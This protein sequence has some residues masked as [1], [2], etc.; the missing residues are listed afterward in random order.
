[1]TPAAAQ[2]PVPA[3]HCARALEGTRLL[4]ARFLHSLLGAACPPPRPAPPRARDPGSRPPASLRSFSSDR[5]HTPS[6]A[7]YLR[8]SAVIDDAVVMPS[9]QVGD[10]ALAS[11]LP[12]A[13]SG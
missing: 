6:H 7:S 3:L 10:R 4:T 11:R 9:H 12:L 8:D 5:S 13:V 2:R 1:M